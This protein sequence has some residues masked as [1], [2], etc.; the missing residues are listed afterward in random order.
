M[1]TGGIEYAEQFAILKK[2][3]TKQISTEEVC[4]GEMSGVSGDWKHGVT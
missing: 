4:I 2:N 3:N 1:I